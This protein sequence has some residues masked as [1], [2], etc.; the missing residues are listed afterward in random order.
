MKYVFV[1]M[2]GVIAEYGY[3]SGL[4]DGDFQKGNYLGKKPVGRIIEEII[5]KYNNKDYIIMVCSASPNA[6]A[7]L[8]KNEWLNQNFS[9][10]YENRI[11]IS[12]SED[13]VEVI[14]YYIEDMLHGNVQEHALIIDDKRD[15]LAKAHSLGIECY[16][17][18]QLL[19]L[20]QAEEEAKIKEEQAKAKEAE[21][22]NI[23]E[24]MPEE[25]PETTPEVIED[26]ELGTQMTFDDL[27][28]NTQE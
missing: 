11:F 22:E 20:R 12:P 28:K 19:A 4:Y 17:P 25:A 8:E 21:N 27:E 14:R 6:K 13:K 9:V 15:I 18:T 16:H 24:P 3:P 5:T 1:D 10:P 23:Q 7:I 26:D 2:D